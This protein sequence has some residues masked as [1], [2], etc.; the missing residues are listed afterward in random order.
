LFH[1]FILITALIL[2]RG[3]VGIYLQKLIKELRVLLY[4]YCA[5]NLKESKKNSLK[6]FLQLVD[7]YN[8]SHMFAITNTEKN[9]YLKLAKMPSGPTLTFKIDK[10]SL[11]GD[12]AE[13]MKNKRPLNKSFHHVPLIILNGFNTNKLSKEYEEPVKVSST[14]FQSIFP[15]LNLNELD[16]KL[17]KK[18]ILMNLNTDGET[19]IFEMRHYDV[20]VEKK[21]SKKTISNILNNKKTD[22]S[23]YNNISE[24]ILNQ[25]GYT[26]ASDNEGD[27]EVQLIS[28]RQKTQKI[29]N[30]DKKKNSLSLQED[31]NGENEEENVN[32][33]KLKKLSN[34]ETKKITE[35]SS[36][37]IKLNEIGPR[38]NLDLVK[39]EEGFF[40]G[41][42][43]FH[44]I[45]KKSKKEIL[46]KAKLLKEKK[47]EKKTRREEQEKNVQKKEELRVS[48]LSPEDLERE[49]EKKQKKDRMLRQKRQMD[50]EKVKVDTKQTVINKREMKHLKNL[51]MGK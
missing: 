21:G 27:N 39:I 35:E 2:R 14:M 12:I 9:S 26:D 41:N 45:V 42:I 38:L 16:I 48:K 49:Q 46:E 3:K 33:K 31:Q 23:G 24:Y 37:T 32:A 44:K 51:K 8:L 34:F 25:T 11:S 15:P 28:E 40:K 47:L 22:F 36:N 13:I 17:A 4:P 29:E 43:A 30:N 19:P 5:I 7:M 1:F 50:E 18:V 10:Y 6:D 20:D